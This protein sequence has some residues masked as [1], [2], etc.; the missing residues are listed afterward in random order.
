[1]P[2]VGPILTAGQPTSWVEPALRA[3]DRPLRSDL[4]HARRANRARSQTELHVTTRGGPVCTIG[5]APGVQPVLFT[6]D[7]CRQWAVHDHSGQTI[8]SSSSL[9]VVVTV[10]ERL[11]ATT[12]EGCWIVGE[13]GTHLHLTA[14]DACTDQPATAWTTTITTTRSLNQ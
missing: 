5:S 3:G 14:T 12:A 8:I 7:R 2:F 13:D 6:A 9:G 11:A 1:M 4:D 10:A